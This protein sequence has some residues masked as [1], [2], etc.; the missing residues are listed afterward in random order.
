MSFKY[1]RNIKRGGGG[2]GGE[3][4]RQGRGGAQTGSATNPP[5]AL[6]Q[7]LAHHLERQA[8]LAEPESSSGIGFT[9]TFAKLAAKFRAASPVCSNKNAA[10]RHGWKHSNG[11]KKVFSHEE[12]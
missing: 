10:V 5:K 9:A 2:G 3:E 4:P 11:Q 1:K 6:V 8:S 12:A 7:R